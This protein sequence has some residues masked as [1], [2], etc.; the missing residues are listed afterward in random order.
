MYF[1]PGDAEF[2]PVSNTTRY[3]LIAAS[4]IVLLVGLY[5]GLVTGWL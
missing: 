2:V 4:A 1:K 5:P 3:A